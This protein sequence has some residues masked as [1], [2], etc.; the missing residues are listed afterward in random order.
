MAIQSL[1]ARM[2]HYTFMPSIAEF[3]TEFEH[4]AQLG[5]FGAKMHIE[6]RARQIIFL[7]AATAMMFNPIHFYATS[8][9]EVDPFT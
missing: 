1:R 3:P 8:S 2:K 6:P 5:T 7:R 9:W 4:S